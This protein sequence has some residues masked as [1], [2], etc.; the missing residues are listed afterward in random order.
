MGSER[1]YCQELL[2][3]AISWPTLWWALALLL[4]NESIVM[5]TL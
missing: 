4:P 3:V 5:H 2:G 1:V